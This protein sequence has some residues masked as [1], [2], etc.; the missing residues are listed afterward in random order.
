MK[1]LNDINNQLNIKTKTMA[2]LSQEENLQK[3]K[4]LV[5]KISSRLVD[6]SRQWKEVQEPLLE[7]YNTLQ[8]SLSEKESIL[9]EE[10][11]KLKIAIFNYEELFNEL[12][13][14]VE[15]EKNWWKN[16]DNV[17]KILIGQ[18]TQRT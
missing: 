3:L 5:A 14:K 7:E 9:Q 13:N 17:Q 12:K 15:L 18:L 16:I 8:S 4:L 6:L 1:A 2:V 11:N 10:G